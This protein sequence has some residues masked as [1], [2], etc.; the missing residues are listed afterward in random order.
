[1]IDKEFAIK[2]LNPAFVPEDE[3]GE[4]NKRFFRE[5]NI[6]FD[7]NQAQSKN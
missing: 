7:V 1:M 3:K 6:H 5:G 4:Y 2:I